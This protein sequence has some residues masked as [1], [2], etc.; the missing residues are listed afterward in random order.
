VARLTVHFG[1]VRVH[2]RATD[3]I[4]NIAQKIPPHYSL[5]QTSNQKQVNGNHLHSP[6]TFSTYPSPPH[7]LWLLFSFVRGKFEPP[8]GFP[9]HY[10]TPHVVHISTIS[11]AFFYASKLSMWP[12]SEAKH[13]KQQS[14][15]LPPSPPS[16]GTVTA[17][18]SPRLATLAT[19]EPEIVDTRLTFTPPSHHTNFPTSISWKQQPNGNAA[20]SD[21]DNS[22]KTSPRQIPRKRFSRRTAGIALTLPPPS[23]LAEHSL[24]IS[25]PKSARPLSRKFP[26]PTSSSSSSPIEHLP[27]QPS[28]SGIGRKVAATLQLFKETT[29]PSEEPK[30]S[31]SVRPE[32]S[33]GSRRAGS[34]SKSDDVA[35]AQFEFVKRSE[36]PDRGS[37]AVRREKSSTAL[38]RERTRESP[39]DGDAHRGKERKPSV[40]DSVMSDLTQWRKD[41]MVGQDSSRGRRRE[42]VTDELVFDMDVSSDINT[43]FQLPPPA[44]SRP[45]SRAY[46]PSPSPSRPPTNRISLPDLSQTFTT[47]QQ[48]SRS[49]TPNQTAPSFPA[50]PSSLEAFSPWSTDDEEAWETASV[51]TSNSMTSTTSANSSPFSPTQH[52]THALSISHSLDDDDDD[53]DDNPPH[54][55]AIPSHHGKGPAI[56]SEGQKENE[57]FLDVDVDLSQEH[58]PHIPLRPFRNQVGGHSAIY[59]FTRRAVCKVCTIS[60]LP[61][62]WSSIYSAFTASSIA[63]ESLLRI[64][65]KGGAPATGIHSTVS[66]CHACQLQTRSE[67][68]NRIFFAIPSSFQCIRS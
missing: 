11:L 4:L 22:E 8:D 12:A 63:R 53:D 10:S 41:V 42:R 1:V 9:A 6:L 49:P 2:A 26:S 23:V 15:H 14:Y 52:P 57:G 31:E 61:L 66:G 33:A 24:G 64:C 47:S 27:S 44:L 59:K 25:P 39:H 20:S 50:P 68:N 65:R 37:A 18:S 35:E 51:T 45:Q 28:T 56:G 38:E 5:H 13:P 19:Q 36:W 3:I 21:G 40:R 62:Y 16:S 32:N 7:S 67:R 55:L 54:P 43:T 34:S 17:I 58:L 46:P 48:R 29:G 30:S 60:I